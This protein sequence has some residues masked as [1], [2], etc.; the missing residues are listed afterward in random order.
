[1][2]LSFEEPVS[3]AIVVEIHPVYAFAKLLV[4]ALP[5][6]G[7]QFCD[8]VHLVAYFNIKKINA[9]MLAETDVMEVINTRL[10]TDFIESMLLSMSFISYS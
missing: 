5:E 9:D 6:A 7:K 3:I 1:M 4:A 10:R 2:K 8:D